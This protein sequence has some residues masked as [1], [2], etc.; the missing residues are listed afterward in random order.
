MCC[1]ESLSEYEVCYK[2]GRF[3]SLLGLISDQFKIVT[4]EQVGENLGV[5]YTSEKANEYFQIPRTFPSFE[6]METE[7]TH[8]SCFW[9]KM[10]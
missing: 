10:E 1:I 9:S 3:S 8:I 5:I 2:L 6:T 4:K 7:M